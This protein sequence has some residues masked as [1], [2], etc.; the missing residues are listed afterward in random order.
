M[1]N[2]YAIV[3]L[4]LLA[5]AC[6][7]PSSNYKGDSNTVT[8][9]VINVNNVSTPE[10]A[11]LISGS[12]STNVYGLAEL[13][14]Q[15]CLRAQEMIDSNFTCGTARKDSVSE[16]S[17]TNNPV[18][19]NYA[20]GYTRILNCNGD[21]KDK[22]ISGKLNY[23]GT[24]NDA[25]VSSNNTGSATYS[26][27]GLGSTSTAYNVNGTL[28]RSGSFASKTD[29]TNHGS[30]NLNFVVTNM[31]LKKPSLTIISGTVNFTLTGNVALKG[32]FSYTG[33]I[34]FNG[35]GNSKVTIGNTS[36]LINLT[37]GVKTKN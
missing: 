4:L 3:A 11:D 18:T 21:N 36:Y 35:D 20:L 37:T 9:V 26:V 34:V 16:H 30:Y 28:L 12:L 2:K 7:N 23:T 25:N 8:P 10:A 24:F 15:T 17:A 31:M 27:D 5:A 13:G 14:E 22:N 29:T 1:K 33:T 19:F 32:N 6:K